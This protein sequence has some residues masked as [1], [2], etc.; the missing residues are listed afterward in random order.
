MF[1]AT[2]NKS[3]QLLYLSF[4]A[5]VRAEEIRQ[6]QDEMATLIADLKSGFRLLTD[7]GR[8]GSREVDCA[9]EIGKIMELCDQNGVSFVVRVI[10]DPAKD[11]GLGILSRFH[12][13]NRPRFVTCESM[14]EAAEILSL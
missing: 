9:P 12:Y 1:L 8:L 13:P 2:I 6:R 4:I 14:A 7:L 10:P 3:K 11:V 5:E